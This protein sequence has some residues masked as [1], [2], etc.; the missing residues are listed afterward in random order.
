MRSGLSTLTSKLE[1]M[2]KLVSQEKITGDY[3]NIEDVCEANSFNLEIPNNCNT[4]VASDDEFDRSPVT[5]GIHTN[6]NPDIR[7]RGV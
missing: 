4:S 2:S 3:R 7:E 1:S 6:E 5:D